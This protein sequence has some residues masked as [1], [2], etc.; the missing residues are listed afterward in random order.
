M[1]LDYLDLKSNP[2][3]LCER[4]S[5]QTEATRQEHQE[6]QKLKRQKGRSTEPLEC[7]PVTPGFQSIRWTLDSL[8]S[9]TV[10]N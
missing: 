4:G 1:V 9:K 5:M 8:P 10:R 6:S 3:H 7:G 2:P